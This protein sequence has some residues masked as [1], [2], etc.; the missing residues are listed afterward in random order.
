MFSYPIRPCAPLHPG[1]RVTP[2]EREGAPWRIPG[3]LCNPSIKQ[4]PEHGVTP[5]IQRT[6]S[7]QETA[8]RADQT[9]PP[10][11]STSK[12]GSSFHFYALIW[13]ANIR[14]GK[15]WPAAPPVSHA[16]DR[17]VL[18]HLPWL[19]WHFSLQEWISSC[20]PLLSEGSSGRKCCLLL[21]RGWME[22]TDSPSG[23]P[24]S[25][26]LK[27]KTATPQG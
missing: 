21:Y 1:G 22:H 12:R 2:K 23:P 8:R 24:I 18:S 10:A 4:R 19:L 15:L 7:L 27:Q 16:A 25:F 9:S 3:S 17:S 14:S 6:R 26:Y 11:R 13:S 5:G 20:H